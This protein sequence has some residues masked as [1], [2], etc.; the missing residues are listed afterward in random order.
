MSNGEIH[1]QGDVHSYTP[2]TFALNN[3]KCIFD[4][5][6]TALATVRNDMASALC[7]WL[8]KL[9]NAQSCEAFDYLFDYHHYKEYLREVGNQRAESINMLIFKKSHEYVALV[10]FK[11]FTRRNSNNLYTVNATLTCEL[12]SYFEFQE[13]GLDQQIDQEIEQLLK[14]IQNLRLA[15]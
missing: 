13:G 14:D 12:L 3:K 9:P 6:S 8:P 1:F 2:D 11:T 7:G 15:L 5:V 4:F 10:K